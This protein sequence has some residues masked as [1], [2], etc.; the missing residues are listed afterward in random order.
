MLVN[1]TEAIILRSKQNPIWCVARALSD[2]FPGV[3]VECAVEEPVFWLNEK[4]FHY[5]NSLLTW[6]SRC[7]KWRVIDPIIFEVDYVP[8][9]S[10][11]PLDTR[12]SGAD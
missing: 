2:A 11:V 8:L 4:K 3:K 9:D 1:I 6:L 5:S 10:Q 7:A 12:K